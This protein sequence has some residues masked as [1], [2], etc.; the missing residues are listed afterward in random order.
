[1]KRFLTRTRNGPIDDIGPYPVWCFIALVCV[2]N[3]SYEG[4]F[5]KKSLFVFVRNW[6]IPFCFVFIYAC[7]VWG[8]LSILLYWTFREI[9]WVLPRDAKKRVSGYCQVDCLSR[10]PYRW[11]LNFFSC[12]FCQKRKN[13]NK[14]RTKALIVIQHDRLITR[15]QMKNTWVENWINRENKRMMVAKIMESRCVTFKLQELVRSYLWFKPDL[16]KGF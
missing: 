4:Y 12:R 3:S 6:S 16:V 2:N 7:H 9:M 10:R 11:E 8:A 1:M 14:T 13:Q 5:I 15:L